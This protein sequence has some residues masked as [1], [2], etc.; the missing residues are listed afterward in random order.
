[1]MHFIRQK[2]WI[3]KLRNCLRNIVHKCA[4]CARLNACTQEQLMSELPKE[5]VQWGKPFLHTGIDYAGPFEVMI[6]GASSERERKKVWVAIFV[7]LKT[8]AMH[9][10]VVSD[11]SSMA[12]VECYE[13]FIARRGRC[14]KMFSDNG[15]V[16]VKTDKEL[17][18]ALEYW[19]TKVTLDH[20][21]S[22]GTVWKFMTAAAPH[23]GGIY[24]AAVKSMKFHLKKTVGVKIMTHESLYTL[25][26]QIEAILNSRPINPLSDDPNDLQA[27]TPGHFL[28]GEPLITPLPFVID[29]KP[30]SMGIKLWRERQKIVKHFWDRWREE[31]L[32]TLQERKKWRRE[33]EGLKEGQ[34]VIVKAEN[35]PPTSW[36]LGRI[37]E[38]IVSKDGLIRNAVVKT[39]TSI[40]RRPVQKLC[41]LPVDV[42]SSN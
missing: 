9:I 26:T 5:R 18:K 39:S 17:R 10:D 27:L 41:I 29:S 33:R 1:M 21:H 6:H 15:G 35:C 2:Y 36:A 24:E 37:Q 22:K 42:E 3:P 4:I 38:V 7:C 30:Q 25:L 34:L 19:I 16:F 14:E 31:Y 13:R 20:M 23:Q 12:F 11:Q 40:L 28:V 8:R 32:V